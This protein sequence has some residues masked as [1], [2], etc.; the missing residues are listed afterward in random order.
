VQQTAQKNSLARVEQLV[1]ALR[2]GHFGNKLE[3]VY[4]T[5]KCSLELRKVSELLRLIP[6]VFPYKPVLTS[7]LSLIGLA[8]ILNDNYWLTE[9]GQRV[10]SN[11]LNELI[12]ETR[13]QGLKEI[14]S[15]PLEGLF[16]GQSTDSSVLLAIEEKIPKSELVGIIELLHSCGSKKVIPLTNSSTT[17]S[18]LSAAIK[19]NQI[20][21][22]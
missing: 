4:L 20:L 7:N 22:M 17:E 8:A 3:L 13:V 5:E 14:R 10:P 11:E 15:R 18:V 1:G 12:I 21:E 16:R 2:S 6:R 9:L 19:C